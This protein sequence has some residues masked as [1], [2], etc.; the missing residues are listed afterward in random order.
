M[1][2]LCHPTHRTTTR[3]DS[4]T[5]LGNRIAQRILRQGLRDGSNE[6]ND[7]APVDYAP[8]NEPLIVAVPGA[9]M[10]D[11]NRWQPLALEH[12]IA[13][14]GI[15]LPVGP[16]TFVGPHWGHVRSFAM[17]ESETGVPIDPGAPPL[18]HDPVS[19]AAFK[20]A[21]VEVI[22]RSSELDPNDRKLIDISPGA[23]GNNTL[24][25]N[26]GEGYEAN[27]VTGE[28][29]EPNLVRRGDFARALTEFWA[30]GPRSETPPGHWNTLANEVVDS[31]GFTRQLG[32]SGAV[33]RP[34]RVGRQDVPRAERRRP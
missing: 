2:A 30:D 24:G 31:P 26:D 16:Q 23:F 7:Y 21:A 8:V 22:R 15:P 13:Q 4:P 29:Y 27:P 25:A 33:A 3:G 12:S 10:I 9:Q 20:D 6:Q 1:A 18:L 14:N 19:D 17:P 5:A 34:A 32:G 11:P 28:P